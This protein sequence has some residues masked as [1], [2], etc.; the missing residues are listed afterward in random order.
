MIETYSSLAA[1]DPWNQGA[2]R[3]LGPE[4]YGASAHKPF[5]YAIPTVGERPLSFR[6]EGLPPGLHLNPQ[7][8]HITGRATAEGE[9]RIRF[10]ASNSHGRAER[11]LEIRIGQG[12]ALTPPLGWNSWNAWRRWV[13]AD[14]VRQAAEALVSQ[15]LA[16][17]GYTY[18]NVDS[19]WQGARGGPR[20]ALQ[21]NRKFPDMK[22]LAAG[23]HARGLKFGLYS[24]PWTKPWGCSD[25]EALAEWGGPPLMGSTSGER[26]EDPAYQSM[27]NSLVFGFVPH[28]RFVGKIKHEAEDVA[29][30]TAWGMDFLKYDWLGTDPVST[31]RMGRLLRQ[32]SRDVIFGICTDAR[33]KHAETYVRWCHMFRGIQDTADDWPWLVRNHF[34]ADE[35]TNEDWRPYIGPGHWYDLDILA[36][37]PQFQDQT[38]TR[39]NKLTE[40]EQI[41]HMT[42]WAIYPSPLILSCDLTKL[43]DFELR[44]FANEEV[45]A[46]NQDRLGRPAWRLSDLGEAPRDGRA[47]R[48]LR[49]YAREL[50]QG[51]LALGL[52]NLGESEDTAELD[53]RLLKLAGT[54]RVRDAWARRDAG[55]CEGRLAARVAAHGARLFVLTPENGGASIP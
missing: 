48:R 30:W 42:L 12:L 2:P 8:G 17:R 39:P 32:A 20:N 18:V 29:V 35:V 36:L 24:T 31:E 27:R 5:L 41:A 52:F 11:E 21:P 14:H 53:F 40:S 49:A 13:N 19:C 51:R 9:W 46:I 10:E 4:I 43:S 16:A 50:A 54:V 55:R 28:D 1:V 23:I 15:G 22:G 33:L 37:G 3:M 6:A 7:T 25:A 38:S 47:P 26:D 34:N 44:L 45:L